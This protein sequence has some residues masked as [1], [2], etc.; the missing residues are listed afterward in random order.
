MDEIK[1]MLVAL[2]SIARDLHRLADLVTVE[3]QASVPSGVSRLPL[4]IRS[5]QVATFLAQ[6]G[7]ASRAEITEATG[8]P[9]GSLSEV[10]K[11]GPFEQK[12]RGLWGLK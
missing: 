8:V 12:R 2:E 1:R 4:V 3:E 7:P 10:L 6:H 5:E 9:S 11:L